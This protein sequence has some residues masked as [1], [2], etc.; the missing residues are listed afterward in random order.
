MSAKIAVLG[1]GAWGTTVAKVIADKGNEVDI[2]SNEEATADEINQ[3]HSNS[4]F[5]PEV[6]LPENLKAYTDISAVA[7]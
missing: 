2:W 5:L 6:S 4:R 7:D 3:R 1:S